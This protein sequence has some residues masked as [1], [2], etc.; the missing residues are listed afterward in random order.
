M[1]CFFVFSMQEND[2]S[3]DTQQSDGNTNTGDGSDWNESQF[4]L[5]ET[6]MVETYGN[7]ASTMPNRPSAPST[8]SEAPSRPPQATPISSTNRKKKSR[9]H[10]N[11]DDDDAESH[12]MAKC[13]KILSN[14]EKEKD[15]CDAFGE[16]VASQLKRYRGDDILRIQTENSLQ[17]VLI[18]ASE[19]FLAKN[20]LVLNYDGSMS[21]FDSSSSFTPTSFADTPITINEEIIFQQPQPPNTESEKPKDSEK[22][23]EPTTKEN[24]KPDD[25]DMSTD[26]DNLLEFLNFN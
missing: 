22:S 16:Y 12:L 18:D 19:K 25:S 8:S 23:A 24:E 14:D 6:F 17:K 26:P 21:S 15:P 13:M 3:A 11:V 20:Y 10:T 9:P 7:M 1:E 5:T 4:Q 2:F